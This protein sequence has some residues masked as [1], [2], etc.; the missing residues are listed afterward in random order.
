MTTPKAPNLSEDDRKTRVDYHSL[1]Q[2]AWAKFRGLAEAESRNDLI[3]DLTPVM[4][5]FDLGIFRLVVMGEI[6]KGKSSFINALL[7]EPDLLPTASDVATST[8]FKLIYGPQKRFKVFF[9]PDVDTGR[10]QEPL[11]IEASALKDFGTEDGNP[12]N[13]RRVDFIGVELPHALLK[14]GLVVI[15]TPGVGGLFKNHRDITWR[16]APNADAI[17]FVLDSTE[18]VASKDELDFLKELT[19]KVTKL[20]FFVQTKTDIAGTEQ[21]QAWEQRNKQLLTEH[22]GIQSKRLL[23]FPV[24][25]KRKVIADKK[26]EEASAQQ[27]ELMRHLERSGF[28]KVIQFLSQGLM[29]Q[30]EKRVAQNTA[31][32]LLGGCSELDRELKDRYRIVGV[33]S[34][35]ELDGFA[36]QFAEAQK[37]L[38]TW[39]RTTYRDEM[40][41][42]DDKF[43]DLKQ[44]AVT[45]LQ[46]ELDP[47]GPIF[48]RIIGPLR[49]KE[50][51]PAVVNQMAGQIQQECLAE[52]SQLIVSVQN[53][54]NR[55]ALTLISDTATR[56]AKGFKL[57]D[58]DNQVQSPGTVPIKIEDSLH[59]QFSAFE[60][61]R[62]AFYGGMAGT[63]IA[64]VGLTILTAIFPPAG[65]V[66]ML[67][68][69]LGGFIG[70]REAIKLQT[71]NKRQQ[72]IQALSNLLTQ[73]IVKA[74][75]QARNQFTENATLLGR[76]ARE[77]FQHATERARTELEKRLKDVGEARL[78]SQKDAETKGLELGAKIKSIQGITV[79]LNSIVPRK[80]LAATP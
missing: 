76:K 59:I 48:D 54:F 10:R 40:Q 80:L 2:T 26:S 15:D 18:A 1:I 30:K 75:N 56:L 77:T 29:K 60:N 27:E 68:T 3:S 31:R 52:A 13:K 41:Q 24:S 9:Q 39:E 43:T 66:V 19:G 42:F 35:E 17:C 78:N 23:Y 64:T 51:D 37:T 62:T 36:K 45:R 79:S 50:F 11:D 69:A 32:Q 38:E 61:L 46:I 14:E 55:H 5:R 12:G 33:Q 28:L 7:G 74:S 57:P 49:S 21:W 58:G 72:A 6:K 20:V 65:A 34:K 25:S 22:L 73:T 53:D 16:Y 70:G 44:N 63:A 8:V 71:Q 4:E 47:T 67:V